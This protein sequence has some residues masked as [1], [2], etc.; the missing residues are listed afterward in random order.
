[1]E[2]SI[3]IDKSKKPH[4]HKILITAQK[5]N[6]KFNTKCMYHTKKRYMICHKNNIL[7]D[8]TFA[9]FRFSFFTK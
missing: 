5:N 6:I 4:P 8:S 9:F 3:V 7:Q 1:M 2:V